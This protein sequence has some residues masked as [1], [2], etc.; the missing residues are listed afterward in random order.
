MK[1]YT[2]SEKML[3]ALLLLIYFVTLING[4]DRTKCANY[5]TENR[6][7]R[8]NLRHFDDY[9]LAENADKGYPVGASIH[10][11]VTV[12]ASQ[13]DCNG[14][15]CHLACHYRRN[16]DMT[17]VEYN[18][19]KI[20]CRLGSS[21]KWRSADINFPKER[22]PD[23]AAGKAKDLLKSKGDISAHFTD[24]GELFKDNEGIVN[25]I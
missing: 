10:Y 5:L 12:P 2:P 4:E 14:L 24:Y 23:S 15:I 20:K 6:R 1:I 7:L 8:L 17:D 19:S 9:Y 18:W 16:S 25:E 11:S 22:V 3:A 13:R 21:N